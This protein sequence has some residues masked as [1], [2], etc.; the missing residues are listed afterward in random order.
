[1]AAFPLYYSI[2]S[3]PLSFY[4]LSSHRSSDLHS[5]VAEDSFTGLLQCIK[6]KPGSDGALPSALDVR[7]AN[8]VYSNTIWRVS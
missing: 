4:L 1:M 5:N 3:H 7:I 8:G 2:T 6:H